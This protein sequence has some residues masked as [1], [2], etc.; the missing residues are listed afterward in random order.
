MSKGINKQHKINSSQMQS[1]C[2]TMQTH[3]AKKRDRYPIKGITIDCQRTK[4][5]WSE[6]EET[7]R[8]TLQKLQQ[9]L[10]IVPM[11]SG[12]TKIDIN[13]MEE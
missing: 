5:T 10:T 2:T 8:H 13:G 12:I 6:M 4:W 7:L 9:K 1:I 3:Y 11:S